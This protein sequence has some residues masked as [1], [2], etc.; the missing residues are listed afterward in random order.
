MPVLSFFRPLS[1]FGVE[2]SRVDFA[3]LPRLLSPSVRFSL[4]RRPRSLPLHHHYRR[5]QPF[6]DHNRMRLNDKFSVKR[7]RTVKKK[8]KD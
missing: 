1:L 5:R 2:P 6:F 8:S 4:L 7:S 3:V